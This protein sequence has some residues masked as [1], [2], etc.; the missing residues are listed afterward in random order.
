MDP[1][2]AVYY[3]FSTVGVALFV[4]SLT[5]V[6]GF[7][8]LSFSA[9]SMNSSMALLTAITIAIALLADFLFLPPLLMQLE[10]IDPSVKRTSETVDGIPVLVKVND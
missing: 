5:L 2:D 1:A 9:F 3:A 10:R 6:V 8:V 7:A 4:T